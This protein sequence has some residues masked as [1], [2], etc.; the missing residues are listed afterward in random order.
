MKL[1]GKVALITGGGTGIG[2]AISLLFA[3]EGAAVAINYSKSQAEALE[4][5]SE[6]R[7]LGGRSSIVRTDVS[8]DSQVRHMME[9]VQREFGAIDILIN[10]AGF[11]RFINFAD[12]EE[13]TE[14]IWDSLFAV[15]L[16]G[17]FFCCRAAAP[18]MQTQGSGRIVNIAS[19][20]GITGQ[21]SCIAYC[22]AKAGV[23]SLTKSLARALGPDILVNGVAPAL[24]ETRWLDGV[25]RAP[26]MRENFRKASVLNRMGTAEDVAEVT[27]SMTTDWSFVTGQTVVVDGGR[28]L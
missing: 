26:Q 2:R 24:T 6:V 11:T 10:N 23:I 12:L 25:A 17:T 19:V 18:L 20:A 27:L 22:A 14:G 21:G 5:A 16:K 1:A 15:N 8:S 9:Q 13:L 3:R 4:T 28:M 7:K